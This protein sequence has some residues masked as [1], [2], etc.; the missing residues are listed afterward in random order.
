MYVFYSSKKSTMFASIQH[1]DAHH[2]AKVAPYVQPQDRGDTYPQKYP[3]PIDRYR[4]EWERPIVQIQPVDAGSLVD[5]MRNG[6]QRQGWETKV[7][8]AA[9]PRANYTPHNMALE[10]GHP[11]G[12]VGITGELVTDEINEDLGGGYIC[13]MRHAPLIST[14]K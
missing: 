8:W 3:L 11:S 1:E 2:R 6:F 14:L 12:K 5:D 10:N 13:N 9:R 4:T 7:K